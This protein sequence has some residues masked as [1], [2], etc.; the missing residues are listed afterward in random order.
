MIGV[1]A[2]FDIGKT[3][4]K[5]L[6]Y[7][8]SYRIVSEKLFKMDEIEDDDGFMG[9]NLLQL[10]NWMLLAWKELEKNKKIEV[11]SVN[12]TSYGASFVHINAAGKPV[13]Q[14][15]N[16]LKPYPEALLDQFY[17]AYGEKEIFSAETASPALGMLNSGLQ[18]YWLKNYKPD[19]FNNI[20][21]SLHLPQ[22]C[23]FLFSGKLNSEM[24][25]VGCHT[26]LWSFLENDY[27][28]WVYKE[29]INKILAPISKNYFEGTADFRGSQIPCG[30]GLHDSSAALIP[31]KLH[32]SDPFL[33]LSTGTWGITLNP[34][35]QKNINVN[36][37]QNDCLK[38]MTFEGAPV[39]ASRIFIG[40]RHEQAVARLSDHFNTNLDFYKTLFYNPAI[41]ESISLSNILPEDNLNSFASFEEAYHYLIAD[42]A[43]KQAGS[44]KL[45]REDAGLHKKI[46]I[47][48]GFS[49]NN[50]FVTMLSQYFPD[51]KIENLEFS[52]G[53][54]LGAALVM[55]TANS[56]RL[57]K[58]FN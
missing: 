1:T 44:I 48:G 26:G 6:L 58:V 33:L 35:S 53:T 17:N 16:Y 56:H 3:N 55:G 45:A 57:K 24:T 28:S 39:K 22:Y 4:K 54:S 5:L 52:Q 25:S 8:T 12:F 42:I 23:A 37:L 20:H 38:F 41:A 43:L 14:L 29:G 40:N 7:D 49:R 46:F 2:I 34:F 50:I 15:Y 19:V 10:R 30:I 47:D 51:L 13:A 21:T 18:L 11:Q 36:D 31:Y 32:S 27:H 9:D